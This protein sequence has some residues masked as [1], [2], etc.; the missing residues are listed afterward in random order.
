MACDLFLHTLGHLDLRRPD[1]RPAGRLRKKDLALLAYLCV[2]AGRAQPRAHQRGRLAALLWGESRESLARHSLTQALSRIRRQLG[3]CALEMELDGVRWAGKM[4]CDAAVLLADDPDHPRLDDAMSLYGGDFLEGFE[5]GPGAEEFDEWAG[6]RR[7]ELRNAALR[8]LERRG[9]RAEAEGRW[10][11]AQRIGENAVRIDPLGEQGHRRVMRALAELGETSRALRYYQAFEAW[12]DE[13]VGGEPDPETRELAGRLRAE[14]EAAPAAAAPV[15]T[16]KRAPG[17]PADFP[18]TGE[19]PPVGGGASTVD[20]ED[21][22]EADEV[23]DADVDEDE[24]EEIDGGEDGEADERADDDAGGGDDARPPSGRGDDA[25]TAGEAPSGKAGT[26]AAPSPGPAECG[27]GE[28]GAPRAGR[29]DGGTGEPRRGS[30]KAWIFALLVL[31]GVLLILM[32]ASLRPDWEGIGGPGEPEVRDGESIREGAHGRVYLAFRDTLYEYPDE[33]TLVRCIGAHT[34]RVRQVDRLPRWPK[35]RLGSVRAHAWQGNTMPVYAQPP[36]AD[37]QHVAVGCVLTA[38]PDLMTFKEVFGEQGWRR[39]VAADGQ[40]LS[41]APRSARP[42]HPYPVRPTGTLIR[43][44]GDEIRWVVY[45]G[46]ALRVP[47]DSVL[48]TYCRTPYEVEQVTEAE[49][50]YYDAPADLPRATPR[51][52]HPPQRAAPPAGETCAPSAPAPEATN[53]ARSPTLQRRCPPPDTLVR[54]APAAIR[55]ALYAG[56]HGKAAADTAERRSRR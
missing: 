54:R 30:R 20:R 14:A 48:A 4:G 31:L 28:R 37:T 7:A 24:D 36:S 8:L 56:A 11:S 22:G 51:C 21:D 17:T 33:A 10:E 27:G 50:R 52:E 44:A 29:P 38:I 18:G 5:A 47:H 46:G 26:D 12:L 2:E 39:R 49:F 19:A 9:V 55:A 43:G 53:G 45:H 16:G 25:P 15:R 40:V 1:G 6:R 13:E 34:G 41:A 35:R 3:D 32:L 42:A 23:A